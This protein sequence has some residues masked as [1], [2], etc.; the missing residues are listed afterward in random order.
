MGHGSHVILQL[1]TGVVKNLAAVIGFESSMIK[2][3]LTSLWESKVSLWSVHTHVTLDNLILPLASQH[4]ACTLFSEPA[5]VPGNINS[6]CFKDL[7]S[8]LRVQYSSNSV[9][10]HTCKNFCSYRNVMFFTTK[11]FDIC[12]CHYSECNYPASVSSFCIMIKCLSLM[13]D[14]WISDLNFLNLK[15]WIWVCDLDRISNNF[16]NGLNMHLSVILDHV[17]Y[18]G[19]LNINDYKIKICT[20]INERMVCFEL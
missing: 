1:S 18:G 2:S 12:Y 16:Y 15:K 10:S 9:P 4:I 3:W 5:A 7:R 8:D 6:S 11:I 13:T 14:V 20:L 17:L 19:A